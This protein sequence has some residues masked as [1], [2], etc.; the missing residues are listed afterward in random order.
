[1]WEMIR[2]IESNNQVNKHVQTN[3][4]NSYYLLGFPIQ[5]LVLE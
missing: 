2:E 4:V 1:M 3:N 5:I